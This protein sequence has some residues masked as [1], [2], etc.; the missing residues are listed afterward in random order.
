MLNK[1]CGNA[2]NGIFAK[3]VIAVR[4]HEGKYLA[5]KLFKTCLII[6]ILLIAALSFSAGYCSPPNFLQFKE[7]EMY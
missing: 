6:Y 7:F 4:F 5:F 1:E 3:Q 2:Y